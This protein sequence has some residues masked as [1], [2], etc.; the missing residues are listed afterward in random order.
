MMISSVGPTLKGM[1]SHSQEVDY[2]TGLECHRI[3]RP[4]IWR[5]A[6]LPD[7]TFPQPEAIAVGD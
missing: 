7:F 4:F 2:G 6:N 5:F 1:R 3:E